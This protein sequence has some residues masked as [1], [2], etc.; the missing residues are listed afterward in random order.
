MPARARVVAPLAL[1]L[2]L[3]FAARAHAAE[4]T[5][6]PAQVP[7]DGMGSF[8][9]A[10]VCFGY[11]LL[12]FAGSANLIARDD[13]PVFWG[14]ALGTAIPAT[15]MGATALGLGV[16][17]QRRHRAWAAETGIDAPPQGLGLIGSGAMLLIAGSAAVTIGALSLN[18]NSG[19]EFSTPR[20]TPFDPL[21]LGLGAGS[22]V[23]GS[24]LLI[25]GAARNGR[26]KRWRAGRVAMT[27]SVAPLAGRGLG[28]GLV[29][30]F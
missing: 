21:A 13:S 16:R 19:F 11:A 17:N 15:I 8:A 25:A 14:M 9:V 7:A 20:P 18:F 24:G 5:P 30:R 10:G 1:A 29:G 3:G 26:F 2:S 28:V 22:I 12:G 4:P 6:T 27:P 23:V